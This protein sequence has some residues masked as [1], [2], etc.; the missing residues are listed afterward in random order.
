[1]EFG[2]YDDDSVMSVEELNDNNGNDESTP[3][4]VGPLSPPSGAESLF[5]AGLAT[6]RLSAASVS[7]QIKV[8][9]KKNSS[10]GNSLVHSLGGGG[11]GGSTSRRSRTT[12]SDRSLLSYASARS[13][14]TNEDFA[15]CI[16]S[17]SEMFSTSLNNG[18]YPGNMGTA[19]TTTNTNNSSN[20]PWKG[21]LNNMTIEIPFSRSSIASSTSSSFHSRSPSRSM[22]FKITEDAQSDSPTMAT[23]SYSNPTTGSKKAVP[24]STK[25]SSSS[26]SGPDLSNVDPAE[27]VYSKAKDVWAWGKTVPIVGFFVNTT[28]TVT[29]KALGVVG[30]DFGEV[31]TAVNNKL[32][33]LDSGVLNPAIVAIAKIVVEVA[34]KSEDTLKPIIDILMS[35][36]GLI[37]SEADESTPD[38]HK[39]PEVTPVKK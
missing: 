1:M 6:E 17:E 2:T 31:D 3:T 36:L 30:T 33:F 21:T 13:L 38:A 10:S 35:K 15:S 11:G 8:N 37:K 39:P 7:Q 5:L 32:A 20:N 4:A 29:G 34:G 22:I 16:G 18:S 19:N 23:T 27:I 28:E 24:S 12:S 26:S 9:H 25:S 14:E